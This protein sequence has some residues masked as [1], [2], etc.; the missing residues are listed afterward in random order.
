LIFK[1]CEEYKKRVKNKMIPQSGAAHNA[2]EI[3]VLH[4]RQPRKLGLL[5]LL[6]Y[7]TYQLVYFLVNQHRTIKCSMMKIMFMEYTL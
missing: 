7:V 2:Q 1:G 6:L 4:P 3:A 5:E